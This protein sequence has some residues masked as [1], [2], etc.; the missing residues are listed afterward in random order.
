MPIAVGVGLK[1]DGAR[2][3]FGGVRGD[4]ERGGEVREVE[5]GFGEEE[6]L[7]G[8]EGG[9]AR[10]GPVPGE[11]LL[12][13]VEEGASD[14]GVVGNESMVKVGEPKERANIFHLGWRRPICDGS[15]LTGSMANWPGFTIMPRYSTSSV[16]NLHFSSFR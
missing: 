3:M 9:L 7:E 12:G 5:D 14:V 4:G 15:S 16:A 10:G 2:R 11:I 6:A 1:E 13:E 8:V